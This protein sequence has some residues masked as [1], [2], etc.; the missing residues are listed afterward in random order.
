MSESGNRGSGRVR[1]ILSILSS[2]DWRCERESAGFGPV[3]ICEGSEFQSHRTGMRWRKMTREG[4]KRE[5]GVLGQWSLIWTEVGGS[6]GGGVALDMVQFVE[7]VAIAC[8]DMEAKGLDRREVLRRRMGPGRDEREDG[9]R[10][11]N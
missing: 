2:T 7:D 11:G 3:I 5:W 1:G 9:E 6:R 10:R 4:L 8:V